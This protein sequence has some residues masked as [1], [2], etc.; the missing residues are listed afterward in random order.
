MFKRRN[1][2]LVHARI[3]TRNARAERPIDTFKILSS[4]IFPTRISYYLLTM[5][6]R[7]IHVRRAPPIPDSDL[8]V[9]TTGSLIDGNLP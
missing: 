6:N 3:L 1:G 9:A 4:F 7:I 8:E 2:I 5:H